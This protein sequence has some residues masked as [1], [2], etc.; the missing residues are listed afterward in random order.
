MTGQ[1]KQGMQMVL[2]ADRG[3]CFYPHQNV[4]S[5][6]QVGEPVYIRWYLDEK[7]ANERNADQRI[8]LIPRQFQILFQAIQ[9]CRTFQVLTVGG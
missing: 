4:N 3:T 5:T 2:Q 1:D 7:E 8:E 6:L 9:P